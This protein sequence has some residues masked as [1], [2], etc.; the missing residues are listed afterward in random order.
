MAFFLTPVLASAG[1]VLSGNYRADPYGTL[2][3]STE[4][5]RLIGTAVG[6]GPCKFDAQRQVLEGNFQGGVL[7]GR[8]T[9]CQTGTTCLQV[10]QAYPIL[11]I[12]N[13]EQQSLVA[14]VR[15]SSGC[16]SAAL[17]D[18]RFVLVPVRKEPEPTSAPPGPSSSASQVANKRTPRDSEAAKK[19]NDLGKQQYLEGKFGPAAQQFEISL[20]YDS[21]DKN[22]MAYMGRGSSLLKLGQVDEAIVAL[23][24]SRIANQKVAPSPSAR[25]ARILYMLGCAYAQKG[26][27][28]KA[29]EYLRQAVRGGYALHETAE[30]DP[31]LKR[32]L[33]NE[34]EFA[35]LVKKSKESKEKKQAQP[36]G[37]PSGP[38]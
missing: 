32:H 37:T 13:E 25:D 1:P 3:L 17:K 9:V 12:Y 14:H 11:A 38:P 30:N 4:G 10:E 27:K 19:A 2:A 36:R 26:D 18:G 29:M 5:E 15:L 33:G 22:W 31:E 24:R 6:G 21:G 20:S 23:E 28:K 8:L 34:P 16:Q 7:V 35:E